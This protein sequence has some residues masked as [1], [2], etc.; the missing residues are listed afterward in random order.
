MGSQ[1]TQIACGKKHTLAFVPSRGRVYSFG[2]GISGQLGIRTII[3]A[4]VPQ[5]VIGPWVS[6]S[7]LSLIES[8]LLKSNNVIIK[9]IFSGGDHC[10]VLTTEQNKLIKPDDFRYYEYL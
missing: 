2:L 3:N 7:G 4:S 10:F 6:P 5:V 1:I 8:H 9:H